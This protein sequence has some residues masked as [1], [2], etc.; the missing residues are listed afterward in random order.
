[1]DLA[2]AVGSGRFVAVLGRA[3]GRHGLSVGGPA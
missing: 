3:A 1:V 2:E